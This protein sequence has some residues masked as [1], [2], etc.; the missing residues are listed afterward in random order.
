[1]RK[2]EEEMDVVV[3]ALQTAELMLSILP[4]NSLDE[5]ERTVQSADNTAFIMVAP[6]ELS[7]TTK[8]LEDQK[9]VLEW[10]RDTILVYK[11]IVGEGVIS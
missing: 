3:K 8:R 1:M 9:K 7:A 10:A 2:F 11:S 4:N 6:L 5:L